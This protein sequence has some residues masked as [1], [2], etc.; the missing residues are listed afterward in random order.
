M[1]RFRSGTFVRDQMPS[2]LRKF[3]P[4][5]SV[6]RVEQVDLSAIKQAGKSLV[7]LDAD[8][9][10]LPWRGDDFPPE[11]RQ[12][13]ENGKSLGLS[14]CILSNTRHPERLERLSKDIDVPYIRAKFKPSR[15]MYNMALEKYSVAPEGA[16]MVGDQLLTDILG[17]NRAGIDAVWIKPIAKREFI[18]TRLISR[19]LERL[20]GWLLHSYFQ[21]DGATLTEKAGFFQHNVVKQFVKFC[22]VGG[23]STVIDLGLH[24]LLMFYVTVGGESLKEIVGQ[25]A[26]S[27]QHGSAV[28]T[29][30]DIYRYAFAPLKVPAVALAILN[31]YYWNRRWTFKVHRGVGHG[32]MMTKFYVVALVGMALNIAVGTF[33]AHTLNSETKTAWLIASVV[34]TAVVVVWN[35]F[36]QR[37][38][39]FRKSSR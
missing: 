6:E 11:V 8:N 19:N 14:F 38:W 2:A 3:S 22:M 23:V 26:W 16:V 9:T 5:S 34:S 18:G 39:T 10:L 32:S 24:V 37:L 31:S 12:W 7:L 21:P 13:I 33:V 17:A 25:W 27:L 4:A 30:E 29:P 35:F 28:A 15:Q 20:V 36:G 1:R